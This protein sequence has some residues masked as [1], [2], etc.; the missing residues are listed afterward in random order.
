MQRKTF[1]GS[2]MLLLA[3]LFLPVITFAIPDTVYISH[4][5]TTYLLFAEEVQLVDI[6]KDNEYLSRI[7]GKCVFV[8]AAKQHTASTSILVQHG[9]EYFVAHLVY[10]P[11]SNKFLYDY[12]KNTSAETNLQK[13]SSK[14]QDT[15]KDKNVDHEKV[16]RHFSSFQK[17]PQ[18]AKTKTIRR[19]HLRVSLTHLANDKEATFLRFTFQNRSSIDYMLDVI[20]FE[21]KEKRGK[22]FSENN[23][24]REFMEPILSSAIEGIE[25]QG[26]ASLPYAI[27]LYALGKRSHLE[28]SFREKQGSRLISLK[29]PT[30]FIN[31][32][33]IFKH[34]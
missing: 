4:S 22:R 7:E 2:L 12:R 14:E 33:S 29:I 32:A 18:G 26:K 13:G 5:T 34:R 31:N 6:G 8:K 15:N 17:S 1:T 11:L 23:V 3:A 30:R 16:R 9:E 10:T 20:T 27:P 19:G 25:A 21:R 24:N 28:V